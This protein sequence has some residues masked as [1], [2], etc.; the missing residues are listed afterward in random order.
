MANKSFTIQY[1]IKARD[2]LSRQANK[3]ARSMRN[4]GDQSD[5]AGRKFKGAGKHI[6]LSLKKMASI[7]VV[8]GATVLGIRAVIREGTKFQDSM[9][10]LSA[11]TGATGKDLKFLE[12]RIFSMSKTYVASQSEVATAIKLVASAKP[13]LLENIDLLTKTTESVLLLKNASGIELADAAQI[14]AESLNQFGADASRASEFVNILAA[15]AKFGSSEI[16]QT[17]AAATI[18]GPAAKAAG[19]S[20]LQLNAAIQTTAKGGIKAEKAGT[21]LNSILGRMRRLG[22]DFKKVGLQGAFE[23]VKK[24]IDGTADSTA[25]AKLEA[26]IFGEEHAKVGLALID[27]VEFLGMY[28]KRLKGTN[29]AQAQADVRMAT[30]GTRLKAVGVLMNEKIIKLFQKSEGGAG[31]LAGTIERFI[32]SMDAGDI[33]VFSLAISGL[34]VVLAGLGETL[35]AVINVA[36]GVLKPFFALLKGIGTAIGQIAAALATMDF[37]QF[38][39]EGAFDIGGKTLGIFG[40]DTIASGQDSAAELLK[41]RVDVGV[42]IGLAQGLEQTSA[43]TVAGAGIRRTDVG[44]ATGG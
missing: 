18:A 6:G 26:K 20:F 4:L 16:A 31:I 13:E 1:L 42:N 17:G 36:I 5:K 14:T 21:A 8:V 34:A 11:I 9:A 35:S 23:I 43:A 27:N 38:D 15:G 41:S 30:F 19:L 33:E 2:A 12:S 44:L 10:D 3:A 29:T 32:D 28:E 40:G 7:A 22:I 25:R 39:F 37:S 24:A